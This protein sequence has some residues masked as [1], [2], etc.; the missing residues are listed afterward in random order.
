MQRIAVI[1][2]VFLS[3]LSAMDH[4]YGLGLEVGINGLMGSDVDKR[5]KP[6]IGWA[7]S[8]LGVQPIHEGSKNWWGTEF[9]Y[10]HVLIQSD[11][12]AWNESSGIIDRKVSMDYSFDHFNL[13]V[14]IGRNLIGNFFTFAGMQVSYLA[15]C[16]KKFDGSSYSCSD[17]FEIFQA[18][19]QARMIMLLSSSIGVDLKYV[20]GFLPVDM[21]MDIKRFHYL[22]SIGLFYLF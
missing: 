22:G 17:E 1:C 2:L 9:Q 3:T 12:V 16:S 20:Q 19:V 14:I 8:G 15:G 10:S 21:G 5:I 7:I 6:G 13:A 11:T 4:F 18:E